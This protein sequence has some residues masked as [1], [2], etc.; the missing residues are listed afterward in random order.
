MPMVDRPGLTQGQNRME[1]SHPNPNPFPPWM[2]GER[3]HFIRTVTLL[4]CCNGSGIGIHPHVRFGSP[5]D[6]TPWP[7]PHTRPLMNCQ[8]SGQKENEG[9]SRCLSLTS[10]FS[11]GESVVERVLQTLNVNAML[12]R[13]SVPPS[14]TQILHLFRGH[15]SGPIHRSLS[16]VKNAGGTRTDPRFLFCGEVGEQHVEGNATRHLLLFLF[17]PDRR[18]PLHGRP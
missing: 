6:L 7:D 2:E 10:L 12:M 18:W 15:Y 1:V 4:S 14:I 16:H 11:E 5:S 8:D 13:L 17:V 9:G 3:H